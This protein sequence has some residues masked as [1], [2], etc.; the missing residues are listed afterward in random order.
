ME[1]S[2]RPAKKLLI[3]VP[4]GLQERKCPEQMAAFDYPASCREKLN[5]WPALTARLIRK[6]SGR[7]RLSDIKKGSNKNS[8]EA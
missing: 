7:K 6:P 1:N 5:I 2:S 3:A 4:K 8:E